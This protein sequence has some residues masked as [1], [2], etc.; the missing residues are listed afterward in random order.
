MTGPKARSF[1][2]LL[3]K[4]QFCRYKEDT[5]SSIAEDI[6]P[7]EGCPQKDAEECAA[8]KPK[9]RHKIEILPYLHCNR[10]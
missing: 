4:E 9:E 6:Q 1:Y 2:M 3:F 5:A 7:G 8:A 10:K